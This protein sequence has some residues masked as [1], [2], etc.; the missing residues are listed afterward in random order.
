MKILYK[1]LQQNSE[2]SIFN[3][4]SENK[5]QQIAVLNQI[6]GGI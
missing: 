2:R 6:T 4:E 1:K 5:L 3:C